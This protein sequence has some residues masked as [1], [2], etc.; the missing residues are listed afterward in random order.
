MPLRFALLAALFASVPALAQNEDRARDEQTL[1]DAGLALDGPALLGYI[2]KRSATDEQR[3]KILALIRKTGDESFPVRQ[4]AST[5]IESF[6]YTAIGL[7]KQAQ[8]D[9]NPEIARR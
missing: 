9:P 5:E 1:R 8:R 2:R 7:L 6:G 3:Q 4:R